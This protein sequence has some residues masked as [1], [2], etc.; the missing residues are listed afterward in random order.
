M[1]QKVGIYAG[2]KNSDGNIEECCVAGDKPDFILLGT[3]EHFE[4]KMIFVGRVITNWMDKNPTDSLLFRER[5]FWDQG[6]FAEDEHGKNVWDEVAKA[7]PSLKDEIESLYRFLESDSDEEH[8]NVC[9]E[10]Q[11]EVRI[12]CLYEGSKIDLKEV[13]K[14]N[15]EKLDLEIFI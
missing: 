15:G 1:S 11:D 7:F 12:F 6:G 2:R 9:S 3:F 4:H 10:I 13:K 8:Y 5:S 14:G